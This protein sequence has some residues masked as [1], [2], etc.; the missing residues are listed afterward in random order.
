MAGAAG[1]LLVGAFGKL[2]GLDAFT[3]L[4]GRSPGNITGGERGS[5]DRRG[6]R[7]APPHSLFEMVV[8]AA[9]RHFWAPFAA[10]PQASRSSFSEAG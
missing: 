7:A 4:V 1:G 6:R 5:A 8:R 2:L 10:A 9:R 3:L